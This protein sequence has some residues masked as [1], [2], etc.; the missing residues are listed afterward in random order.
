MATT[1]SYK[2]FSGEIL[3]LTVVADF[4]CNST[5][6]NIMIPPKHILWFA[7]SS[8]IREGSDGYF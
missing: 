3:E 5:Y 8:E 2:V 6:G 1:T 7:P 4:V